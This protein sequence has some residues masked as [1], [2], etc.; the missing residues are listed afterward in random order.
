VVTFVDITVGRRIETELRQTEKM[1]ALGKLSAGLTHEL[2]NP[3]AA[4][5]RASGLLGEALVQLQ[6]ANVALAAPAL[7]MASG[8][9]SPSGMR[10]CGRAP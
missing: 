9:R 2:N 7:M 4:A 5:G 6:A 3:A 1:A 10:D 8:R